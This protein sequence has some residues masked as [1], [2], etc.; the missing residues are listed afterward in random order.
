MASANPSTGSTKVDAVVQKTLAAVGEEKS[1]P[2]ALYSKFALAGA[3]C[4]SITHGGLTPVDVYV[5]P[6]SV[7]V[8]ISSSGRRL[9][10]P[11]AQAQLL[12]QLFAASRLVSNSIQSHITAVSLAVSDRLSQR[13]VLLPFSPVLAQP[14][15][16]TSS[17]V[18]SS[19]EVTSS[20]SNRPST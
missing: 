2:L 14:S 8:A 6:G 4:C 11:Y 5:T 15:L 12:I 3:L 10:L 7:P 19:L 20:S 16:G 13:R 18:P 17:K 9:R 1:S